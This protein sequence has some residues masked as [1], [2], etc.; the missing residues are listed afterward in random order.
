MRKRYTGNGNTAAV[1]YFRGP[2]KKGNCRREREGERGDGGTRVY[3][4]NIATANAYI[5]RQL[6][7][8][9]RCVRTR[10]F[11]FGEKAATA[12]RPRKNPATSERTPFSGV[13][14]RK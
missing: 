14:G 4:Y 5:S 6:S 12:E 1:Y 10:A 11:I 2:R 7:P 3:L 8:D 9:N 13:G